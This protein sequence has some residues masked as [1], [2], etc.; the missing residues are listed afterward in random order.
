MAWTKAKTAILVGAGVLV[1]TGTSTVIVQHVIARSRSFTTDP[2][3]ADDAR[4][5]AIDSRVLDKLPPAFI[6]RPTRFLNNGG[7]V[8]SYNRRLM[9]DASVQSLVS[10]AYSFPDTR[11]IFPPNL[12]SSTFDLLLT[13]PD[14]PKELLQEEIKKRFGLVTH[15]ERRE[16]DVFR[17]RVGNP[18]APNLKRNN[19]RDQNAM[20]SGDSYRVTIRNE[21]L[22]GFISSIESKVERPLLD[23]THLK[24]WYDLDLQWKPKPGESEKDAYRR[25]LSE[26][27]GLEL[28]PDRAPIELLVVEKVP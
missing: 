7:G 19:H 26:Q 17:L 10:E 28:V 11:I 4:N 20:W 9:R 12:P 14:H 21:T 8:G 1:A 18:N 24:G 16:V 25:A 15:K 6:L 5:W 22:G 27:L 2:A 13:L 23:E 3:W